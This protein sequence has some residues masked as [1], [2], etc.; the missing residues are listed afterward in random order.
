MEMLEKR[1]K[2]L[3]AAGHTAKVG[4]WKLNVE[5]GE[6]M[7]T[8][9]TFIIH[10]VSSEYKPTFSDAISFYHL[11]DRPIIENAVQRALDTGEPFNLELRLITA[12]GNH[13]WVQMICNP[14]VIEGGPGELSGTFQDVTERR[15][16][17][18]ALRESEEKFRAIS[19]SALD[20]RIMI[21]NNGIITFWNPAAERMFGYSEAE[22]IGKDVPAIL[23][24]PQFREAHQKA[25]ALWRQTGEGG[26]VGKVVELSALRK[27]GSEFPI[28]ISLASVKLQDRWHGVAAVRDITE[29]KQVAEEREQMFL[30]LEAVNLLQ[31]SLLAP[32]SLGKKLK[33]ITDSIVRLV[34]ADFC[35]IWLIRE[36]DLCAQG[37]I[38]A[39]VRE[40]PHVCRYRDRCLHLLSS[41]GRYTHTDGE[42]H[43]RVPFGCYKIGRIASDEE[44]KFLTNDVE[45][46]P[47]VHNHE[48]AHELGLAAFAGY[49]LRV[50]DVGT[51]GVLALF[52]R[53]L[54]SSAEDAMLDGLSSTIALVVQKAS[55]EEADKLMGEALH[56]AKEEAE[57]ANR[58][59]SEFLANMSHEI[60]TPM[61]AIIGFSELLKGR[62]TDDKSKE[63]L[64]GILTGGKNLLGLIED[65]LDLSKIEAGKME[66]HWEPTDPHIFC[67]EM[68]QIFAVRTAEKGIEF[69]IEVSPGLPRGLMLDEVR[70]RQILLNLIGNAIKFTENG[71]VKLSVCTVDHEADRSALDLIVEIQDTGIGI[72][73][74][75]Q[76]MIFRAFQQ[77]EGQSTRRFG[78]TGLGLT[79][80]KRLVEMMGGSITVRSEPGKGSLF[81]VK[82][83]GIKVAALEP[84]SRE[85]LQEFENI[86]FQGS[87]ILL[88]EDI[89]SNRRV[90]AGL[91]E[92]HD[93]VLITAANGLEAVEMAR[94]THPDLILMDIQ[95][96]VM[97]GYEA[98]EIL[99]NEITLS[100]IPVVAFTASSSE[101]DAHRIK[102]LFAGYLR[103]PVTKNRL[104]QELSYFLP[105]SL[106]G[107]EV[108][109][110]HSESGAQWTP[111]AVEEIA[112]E[113][114]T[115]L[116]EE[117]KPRWEKVRSGM[118]VREIKTFARD[119]IE[120]GSSSG[121]I[122]LRDYGKTLHQQTSSFKIDRMMQTLERFPHFL[123]VDRD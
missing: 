90:I 116:T 59:K 95:M 121:V 106:P 101:M 23:I 17:Q 105:H 100:S 65:I 15:R 6:V 34:D 62:M 60:R 16:A 45:N 80:T 28:E 38:H 89:E 37:C 102:A 112:P 75:Q 12:R 5:T 98:T 8:K 113:V 2:L 66:I 33:T 81:S 85:N 91:L 41:S 79:I 49:Q 26:A 19:I 53:H 9:E 119:L 27:D 24:P 82:F 40:G 43:R 96:P 42:G 111:S 87:V 68:A 94:R 58:A 61:N 1:L 117:F 103:K 18:E 77:Q 36:G 86:R 110:G 67:E 11:E 54:I 92:P 31:R 88:A 20:A 99:K 52:S 46:D 115:R 122:S 83:P 64:L 56:K 120:L 3:E 57:R 32:A 69:L 72:P 73:E 13:L 109:S 35:R 39:L 76:E 63:Y 48:W 118:V 14:Q 21:D 51:L 4:G 74:S 10:E 114:I 25:F 29:R 44:H 107:H 97:D 7:W 22:A 50:P 30:R 71:F 78:G 93:L 123:D 47:R 55:M 84:V 70:M 108:S 104:L